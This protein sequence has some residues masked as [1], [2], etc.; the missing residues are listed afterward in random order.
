MQRSVRR[1]GI[2]SSVRAPCLKMGVWAGGSGPT[3]GP[4]FSLITIED[5]IPIRNAHDTALMEGTGSPRLEL[6]RAKSVAKLI[7]A[8]KEV[9]VFTTL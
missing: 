1:S 4:D 9:P 3:C 8:H 6:P 7:T 5:V 2:I